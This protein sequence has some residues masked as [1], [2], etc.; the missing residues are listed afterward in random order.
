MGCGPIKG[1][2]NEIIFQFLGPMG[3]DLATWSNCCNFNS[4]NKVVDVLNCACFVS[5]E[6]CSMQKSKQIDNTD[7]TKKICESTK[8]SKIEFGKWVHINLI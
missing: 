2:V 1:W 6:N 4:L 8:T 7:R 3:E 5:T